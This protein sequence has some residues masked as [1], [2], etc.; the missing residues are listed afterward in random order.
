MSSSGRIS[1]AFQT[2][3]EINIDNRS[4]IALIS[5]CHRSDG[6]WADSFASNRNLFYAALSTYNMDK[7]TYIELGDGEE[8]WETKY[9]SDIMRENRNIY[10]LMSRFY[11]GGRLY[12]I[13]GNHDM[14]KKNLGF[15]KNPYTANDDF[16]QL[17][18]DIRSYESIV[19]NYQGNKI[20]LLHGHQAD[21]FN[22]CLWR[23]G[24]F[25]VR[26]FWKNLETLGVNDPTSASKSRKKKSAVEV[27]LMK[28]SAENGVMLIAGHTHRA[29]FPAPGE[30]LYFNDGSCVSR[31]YISA[32]EI[33]DGNISLVYWSFKVREDGTVYVGRDV[34]ATG[35][36]KSYFDKTGT[37]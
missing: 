16:V 14:V 28:W 8:L 20:L 1:K 6:G 31:E 10:R 37:K 29:F 24:R 2:A 15:G 3:E 12:L 32:I 34:S 35:K 9:F 19:L 30:T 11:V 4:R 36:L 27:G 33:A 25:L 7:Y 26:H 5:D 23:L 22:S 17:F 21:F 13:Y 18:P